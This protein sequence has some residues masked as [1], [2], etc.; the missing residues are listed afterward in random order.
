VIRHLWG[1]AK[2]AFRT[3]GRYASATIRGTKWLTADLCDGTLIRVAKGSVTVRDLVKR[4]S[5]V[6][7]A[8]HQYLALAPQK[9]HK[10]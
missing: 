6:V 3:K 7:R 9:K 8:R 2:G 10:R 5:L 4:R 1:D